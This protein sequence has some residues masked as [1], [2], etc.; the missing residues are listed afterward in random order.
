MV[1]IRPRPL[2]IP[3]GQ[4]DIAS[5]MEEANIP[6]L[7]PV[8]YQLT[9]DQR[10]LRTP[11]RPTRTRGM[12]DHHTGGLSHTVQ[13]EIRSAAVDAVAAWQSGLSPAVP[14]PSS[15]KLHELISTCV[16]E[17]VPRE[18]VAMTAEQMG[19]EPD[20]PIP[21]VSPA[22]DGFRVIVIGFG[23]SGLVVSLQLREAGIDHVVVEKNASVGGTWLE[24][25]YPG[26]G[27]DT[28]SYLYSFSFYQRSWSQHFAKR[29]EL[30]EYLRNM[31]QDLELMDRVRF[32]T[33][34]ISASWDEAQGVWEVTSTGPNGLTVEFYDAVVTATGL[35]NRPKIPEMEGIETFQG[36]SFHSA[37]WPADLDVR[38]KRVAVV[39]S[40]AS[41]MQIVPAIADCV[42]QLTIVQRSPQWIVPNENYFQP[43]SRAIHWLMDH[44]PYYY[45][46]YRFRLGWTFNDKVHPSLQIDPTWRNPKRSVN[47]INDGHRR[48]F[49]QYIQEQLEGRPD[50]LEKALPD[51]PPFGKRMLLDNGWYQV[52]RRP[53]VELINDE[54]IAL[55]PTGVRMAFGGERE[56]DIV[57]FATGFEAQR[58]TFPIEIRGADG[59]SFREAWN[60]DDPH[61]YLGIGMP[62]F[63]NLFFIY[64]PN[65]NLGHGGSFMFLAE[66]QSRLHRPTARRSVER[67]PTSHRM[68]R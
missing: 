33:E 35:L 20:V 62:G 36:R 50:L 46:W 37:R 57:V 45:D 66:N 1:S 17:P 43:V 7:I 13:S 19:F 49:T 26:C 32:N 27:V 41:A 6:T 39:G 8:L 67:Q 28:P 48:R 54:A 18:Y 56:V 31:A 23:V 16:G 44:V 25:N 64:G 58:P 63:P 61:A 24:N 9:G 12:D 47:A 22:A 65:T 14:M 52:L 15:G 60:D 40:G 34:V 51:Y 68:P 3:S 2:Q 5:A 11:Y 38:G 42:E 29:Q 55:T 59:R 4:D 30:E 21:M 10:W 53:N